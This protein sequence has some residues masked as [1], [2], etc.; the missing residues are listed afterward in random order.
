MLSCFVLGCC[1]I[2]NALAPM[3]DRYL[4]TTINIEA[5]VLVIA[6]IQLSTFLFPQI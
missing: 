4:D 5:L 1:T 2:A 3:Y 6:V